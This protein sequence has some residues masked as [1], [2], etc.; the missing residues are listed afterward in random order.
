MNKTAQGQKACRH[1]NSSVVDSRIEGDDNAKYAEFSYIRYRRRR[2]IHCG[3]RFNTFELTINQ[4]DKWAEG[5]HARS[6]NLLTQL[7]H[8]LEQNTDMRRFTDID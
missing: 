2:C 6:D 3:F 4:I 8:L 5:L 7:R 1:L